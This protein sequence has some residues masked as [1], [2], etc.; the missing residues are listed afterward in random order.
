MYKKNVNVKREVSGVEERKV[1]SLEERIPKLKQRRIKKANRRAIMLL[2]LFFLLLVLVLYFL[3]PLSNVSTVKVKGNDYVTNEMVV[4]SSGVTSETSIW[5]I[6]KDE[7]AA[8]L[9]EIPYIKD[10]SVELVLPNTVRITVDEYRQLGY[11]VKNSSYLP[12]L[13]SGKMIEP[14]KKED[15]NLSAPLLFGYEEGRAFE[16]MAEALAKLP[17]EIVNSI[18]EIHYTPTET[19]GYHTTLYM[20][21]GFEVS[22][23]SKT[24]AKKLVHYPSIV[25]QITEGAK[26][27][28]DLEVGSYFRAYDTEGTAA[29]DETEAAEEGE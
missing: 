20:N 4:K 11:V 26:G 25:S 17:E 6:D 8:K 18:S 15:V 16:S 14:M 22:A 2:S 24:L 19:D 3:S 27:V 7:I 21:D 29:E 5:K 23:T 28:I 9:K 12:V 13:E 1:V 10:A